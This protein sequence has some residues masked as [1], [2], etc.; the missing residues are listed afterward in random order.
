MHRNAHANVG[1][2]EERRAQRGE[3]AGAM[4]EEQQRREDAA[5]S[6]QQLVED[7]LARCRQQ[8]KEIAE[9]GKQ[10]R[11]VAA[12]RNR[13][14]LEITMCRGDGNCFFRVVAVFLGMCP[15]GAHA[16]LRRD[17]VDFMRADF[18]EFFSRYQTIHGDD[19]TRLE[20]TTWLNGM[21]MPSVGGSGVGWAEELTIGATLRRLKAHATFYQYDDEHGARD[22]LHLDG[23][24]EGEQRCHH[25]EFDQYAPDHFN[26]ALRVGG[27]Q[28]GAPALGGR[29]LIQ[30]HPPLPYQPPPPPSPLQA[31]LPYQPPPPSQPPLP[32][33]DHAQDAGRQEGEA[34]G[35]SG[36]GGQQGV[37]GAQQGAGKRKRSHRGPG[38]NARR[39]A[40][41]LEERYRTSDEQ[42][43]RPQ[44]D[45]E[46][47]ATSRRL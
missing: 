28:P 25:F 22:Y 10:A 45:D 27:A 2:E 14:G 31:P 36:A 19:T 34:A 40:R 15:E 39:R 17:S 18:D 12:M 30:P 4:I 7:F 33:P 46:E 16:Q 41:I 20:F 24:D 38:H 3:V 44:Q 21:A 29:V 26:A 9:Q 11:Y 42:R 6:N 1:S 43:I 13:Y 47:D 23:C 35:G 32:S 37:D 8:M 5:R